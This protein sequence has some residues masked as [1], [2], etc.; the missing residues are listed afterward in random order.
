VIEAGM[1]CCERVRGTV[2]YKQCSRSAVIER[3]GKFYCKQHDPE[4]RKEKHANRYALWQASWK[5]EENRRRFVIA[6][7]Q[8]IRDIAFG[9]ND[10]VALARGI[11]AKEF[12]E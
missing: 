5:A 12:G 9:H 10:P 2:G 1:K 11:L 6:C 8:A 3:E 4:A 7:E